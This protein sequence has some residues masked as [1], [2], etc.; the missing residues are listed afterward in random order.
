MPH[1]SGNQTPKYL[2]IVDDIYP[3]ASPKYFVDQK[4]SKFHSKHVY[5]FYVCIYD[6]VADY[7]WDWFFFQALRI[8]ED[9][10]LKNEEEEKECIRQQIRVNLNIA[11]CLL[12]L[13][14]YPRVIMHCNKV[15]HHETHDD[16]EKF[17][18][19]A[20]FR[21]AKVRPVHVELLLNK[22]VTC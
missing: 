5:V 1:N 7:I 18:S 22:C 17:F 20:N 13:N 3:S 9:C 10:R 11:Q 16:P 2:S 19:K 14:D 21:K 8:L 4:Y 12:N 15:L 6:F